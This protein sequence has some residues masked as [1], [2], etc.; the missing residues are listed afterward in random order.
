MASYSKAAACQLAAE[1]A[2]PRLV[3]L[4]VSPGDQA[5]RLSALRA[6]Q[7]VV[8]ES[9]TGAADLANCGPEILQLFAII[10]PTSTESIAMRQAAA[11]TLSST[12]LKTRFA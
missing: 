10:G 4:S 2:I 1:G 11:A 3:R 8:E 5:T 12:G 7:V 6:L 9:A